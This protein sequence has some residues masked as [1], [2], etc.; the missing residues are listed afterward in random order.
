MN[1]YSTQNIPSGF[2]VYAYLRSSDNTPYYVG[3]GSGKRA[4]VLHSVT[5]PKNKSRIVILE[6]GLTEIGAFALERRMI[7]WYGRKDIATGILRNLTDGGEGN[8]GTKRKPFTSETKNKMSISKLGKYEGKD[9]PMFGK[10]HTDDVKQLLSKS[11]SEYNKKCSWYNNGIINTFC[12]SMP[13]VHWKLGRINQKPTTKGR[14]WYNN[15]QY[16]KM[17]ITP[18]DNEW[19]LGMK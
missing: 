15:G 6:S 4:W 9:N 12:D 19:Q 8:S 16:N 3:K 13:G 11:K 14:K 10:T 17:F 18:P 7:R 2:Y 5:R 1:I